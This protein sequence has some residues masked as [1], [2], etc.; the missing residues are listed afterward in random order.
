LH[1]PSA[2]RE[3]TDGQSRVEIDAATA[4]EA[5]ELLEARHP[6]I[7]ARLLDGDRL[8]PELTLYLD[9]AEAATGLRTRL[10]AASRLHFLAAQSGG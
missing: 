4:G 9:G 7:K 6:G 3:L 2:L 5:V 8:R 10:T 1:I